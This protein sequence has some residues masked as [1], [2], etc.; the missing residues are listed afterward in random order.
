MNEKKEVA[1]SY[2]I[3]R[4]YQQKV[5]EVPKWGLLLREATLGDSFAKL[6]VQTTTTSYKSKSNKPFMKMFFHYY[7]SMHCRN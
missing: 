5:K 7:D 4:E 1:K 6:I 3:V 2:K